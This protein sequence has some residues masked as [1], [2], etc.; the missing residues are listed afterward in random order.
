ML[1][2]KS[3]YKRN[4]IAMIFIDNTSPVVPPH[5]SH[6]AKTGL[7][8]FKTLLQKSSINPLPLHKGQTQTP[9]TSLCTSTR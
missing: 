8:L 1:L 4:Y 3:R 5:L 2:I 9:F 7:S 6:A